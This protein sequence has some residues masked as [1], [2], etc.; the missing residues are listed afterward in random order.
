MS[1]SFPVLGFEQ[2]FRVRIS[3]ERKGHP[4][5]SLRTRAILKKN[6]SF[7]LSSYPSFITSPIYLCLIWFAFCTLMWKILPR[8]ISHLFST[9]A[10][11]LCFDHPTA[12]SSIFS[13]DNATVKSTSLPH[14]CHDITSTVWIP[15]LAFQCFSAFSLG[16]SS[17]CS[18]L[19]IVWFLLHLY[20]LNQWELKVLSTFTLSKP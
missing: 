9:P 13:A 16:F 8:V 11:L 10:C 19:Y 5:N 4:S 18:M 2:N 6:V 14:C 1:W 7:L 17:L 3:G 12:H 15:A 20:P